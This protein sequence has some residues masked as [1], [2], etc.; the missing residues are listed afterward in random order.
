MFTTEE[1]QRSFP[2]TLVF[3]FSTGLVPSFSRYSKL[4]SL[5]D[6]GKDISKIIIC[7]KQISDVGNQEREKTLAK[8]FVPH[9]FLF[10]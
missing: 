2:T 3:P 5:L 4:N 10:R 6:L 1:F 9:V 7:K 8:C